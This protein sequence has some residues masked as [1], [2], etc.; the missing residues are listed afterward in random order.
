VFRVT[1]LLTLWIFLHGHRLVRLAVV[2]QLDVRQ[3][4]ALAGARMRGRIA[5][6]HRMLAE[7]ALGEDGRFGVLRDGGEQRDGQRNRAEGTQH[8]DTSRTSS[9]TSVPA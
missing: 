8:Q 1:K 2:A 9:A 4:L 7:V 3:T 5:F 6:R